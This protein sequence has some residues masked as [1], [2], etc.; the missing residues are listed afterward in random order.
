MSDEIKRPNVSGPEFEYLRR[1]GDT[2]MKNVRKTA[3]EQEYIGGIEHK[4]D[5]EED[6]KEDMADPMGDE[7]EES[8]EIKQPGKTGY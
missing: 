7:D 2:D 8:A 1:C 3:I 6:A 5:P 4:I